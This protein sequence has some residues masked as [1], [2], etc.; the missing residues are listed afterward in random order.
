MFII[1]LADRL[2]VSFLN[3]HIQSAGYNHHLLENV[4]FNSLPLKPALV[5]HLFCRTLYCLS[6]FE[7]GLHMRMLILP[8]SKLLISQY[9]YVIICHV[10]CISYCHLW[11]YFSDE[12]PQVFLSVNSIVDAYNARKVAC[13]FP[14]TLVIFSFDHVKC[15]HARYVCRFPTRR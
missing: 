4:F 6:T 13:C 12:I 5:C 14:I 1:S 8:L 7:L 9:N 11:L 3:I 10:I 2:T 15:M